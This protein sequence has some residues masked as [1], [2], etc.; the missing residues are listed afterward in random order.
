M[1]RPLVHREP[2]VE[3]CVAAAADAVLAPT[4]PGLVPSD[5]VLPVR[6]ALEEEHQ[7]CG[8]SPRPGAPVQVPLRRARLCSHG[9]EAPRG[10]RERRLGQVPH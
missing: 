2:R 3:L 1:C 6:D 7:N 4:P 10:I 8:V 9:A 5:R